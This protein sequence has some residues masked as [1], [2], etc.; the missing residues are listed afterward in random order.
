MLGSITDNQQDTETINRRRSF[1]ALM[2]LTI[3]VGTALGAFLQNFAFSL[4]GEKLIFRLKTLSYRAILGKDMTWFNR[5]ENSVGSL[6]ERLSSDASTAVKGTT[7]ARIGLISQVSSSLI[8]AITLSFVYNWKL[9]SVYTVFVPVILFATVFLTK[10]TTMEVNDDGKLAKVACEAIG[11]IRT[12]VSLGKEEA[13][14]ATYIKSLVSVPKTLASCKSTILRGLGFGLSTNAACLLFTIGMY[15]GVHLVENE[16]F[17]YKGIFVINEALLFGM[18]IVGLSIM[19]MPNFDRAELAARRIFR[20]LEQKNPHNL[21][22]S[23]SSC[24]DVT[25]KGKIEFKDVFFSYP[26]RPDVDVLK[27]LSADL[28]HPGKT[29]ALVGP[30]GCGKSTCIQL[31]QRFYDPKSG[32]INIDNHRLDSFPP[33]ILRRNLG[34]VSQEPVLFNRTL[35]E[36]IAYG[37]D[38]HQVTMAE[39]IEAAKKANI[40]SFIQ[41]LP[42]GYETKVG[43]RGAQLSGGQKQRVAIARALLRDPKILLLD[44]ATSALDV[45]SGTV[46]QETLTA[47]SQGRT[48]ICIAHRLSSIQNADLIIVIDKGQLCE[49]GKHHDL[50]QLKGI[51]HQLWT[52]QQEPKRSFDAIVH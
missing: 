5:Q 41:S 23:D 26:N 2:F 37:V 49:Q 42:M 45:E 22:P 47:A 15:Y 4:T 30:S 16:D 38:C 7:G 51:Y 10:L 46:V 12:V 28:C 31:I 14:H 29:V 25:I 1:Y 50:M 20:L 32:T 18:E 19:L 6:C 34:I 3:A 8:T 9:A 52:A 27:G 36:N 43:Q 33:E 35:A 39:I 44:E 11:S 21:I 48:C 17:D 13:F 40:H 24:Q